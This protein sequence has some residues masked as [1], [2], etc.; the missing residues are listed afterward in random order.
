MGAVDPQKAYVGAA[1]LE[2]ANASDQ[3]DA[4]IRAESDMAKRIE[5]HTHIKGDD[6]TVRM[7]EIPEI[8][9]PAEGKTELEPGG[10]HLMFLA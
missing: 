9:L 6:D 10:V 7:E 8:I 1:Y 4:V 2:I 3:A 5:L